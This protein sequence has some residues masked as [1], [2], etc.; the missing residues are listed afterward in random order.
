MKLDNYIVA[1]NILNFGD[2]AK[3]A[4]IPQIGSLAVIAIVICIAYHL[5]KKSLVKAIGTGILGGIVGYFIWNPDKLL[6]YGGQIVKTL[7]G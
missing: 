6:T 3:N 2:N 1:S 4:L 5:F 7:F